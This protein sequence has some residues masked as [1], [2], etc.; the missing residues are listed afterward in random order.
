MSEMLKSVMNSTLPIALKEPQITRY[1][2]SIPEGDKEKVCEGFESYFILNILKE[3]EKT[4]HISKKGFKEQTYMSI[5][6]EKVAD[7]LAHK[8]I[9]IKEMLMKYADQGNA[10]VL[11]RSGDNIVK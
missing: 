4:T 6:Y 10:K 7:F 1:G 3:M 5:V 8:G 9:G 11:K 2:Q